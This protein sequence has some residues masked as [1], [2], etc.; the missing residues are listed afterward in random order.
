MTLEL[1]RLNTSDDFLTPPELVRAM[2]IFDLDPCS[3]ARQAE[4]LAKKAF[5]FP[6]EDGLLLPWEG[7]VFV[8]P[9]FSELKKWV[10]RF[11]LH[12]NGVLLAPARVEVAWFW[13][14]WRYCDGIFLTQG[15]VKYLCPPGKSPP[16][17]FGGA[18]CA[19]GKENAVRL[20]HIPLKGVLI[21][22][23]LVKETRNGC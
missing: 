16:G 11:V 23:W 18:F 3:S 14:L 8:N 15:P 6:A 17:F 9:P 20:A 2:G 12:K 10:N 21:N 5:K 1:K 13:D 19:I 7:R 4:P 22:Q